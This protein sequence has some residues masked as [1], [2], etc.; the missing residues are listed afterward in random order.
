[1]GQAHRGADP[2]DEV[3]FAPRHLERLRQAVSDLSWLLGRGYAET[4]ALEL[5]G[6]RF[7]LTARQRAAVRRCAAS[8]EAVADR[9]ARQISLEDI[10]DRLLID[11]F[12]VLIT[13]E[14]ALGGGAILVGRDGACRDLAGVHGTWRRVAETDAALAAVGAVLEDKP[15]TWLLDRPVSN[16]GRLAERIR[17]LA[18]ERGWPW[19]AEVVDAPDHL[20]QTSA[21]PIATS[22][23]GIL[24]RCG[25]WVGLTARVI[26]REVPG[27][28]LVDLGKPALP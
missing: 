18:V 8:D 3:A 11:G 22:D 23:A 26:A 20:L 4:A 21:V 17:R 24:D 14:R 12:N 28:W 27:A 1:M 2:E 13:L 9:L 10:G 5:V 7:Q 15:A 25:P 19:E 16:S 6:N